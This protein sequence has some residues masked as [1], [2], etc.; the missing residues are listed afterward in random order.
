LGTLVALP[1]DTSLASILDETAG[2]PLT[3][4]AGSSLRGTEVLAIERTRVLVWNAGRREFIDFAPATGP[5]AALQ[6]PPAP[7]GMPMALGASIR[8]VG[9]SAYELP[10]AEVD[11]A[12]ANTA[13]LATQARIVPTF[14]G[15]VA[16]GFKLF[17]I[18][19]DSLFARLGLQNGDIVRRLNGLSLDNVES[20]LEAYSRLREAS[21]IE[22]ELERGGQPVHLTYSVQG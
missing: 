21:R 11:H 22:L 9:P 16:Q 10:R 17:A 19:P 4:W 15:G 2:R 14:R 12:L 13:Q 3:V 7:A 18:R 6:P 5:Q 8:Q 1:P 20:A